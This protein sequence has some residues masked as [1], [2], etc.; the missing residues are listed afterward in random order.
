MLKQKIVLVLLLI[1]VVVADEYYQYSGDEGINIANSDNIIV[2]KSKQYYNVKGSELSLSLQAENT[3]EYSSGIQRNELN[4]AVERMVVSGSYTDDFYENTGKQ[5]E[6]AYEQLYLGGDKYSFNIFNN[7]SSNIKGISLKVFIPPEIRFLLIAPYLSE[8]FNYDTGYNKD[9]GLAEL[10]LN[11]PTLILESNKVT[12]IPL[13]MVWLNFPPIKKEYKI[14]YIIGSE[15]SN[16]Q[17]V[18]KSI[19]F[20]IRTNHKVPIM[21]THNYRGLR[22][23]E[24]NEYDKAVRS[25]ENAVD[26][27]PNNAAFNYNLCAAYLFNRQTKKA[28]PSC[29]KAHKKRGDKDYFVL[30]NLGVIYLKL[31]NYYKSIKYILKALE[32]K[33]DSPIDLRNLQYSLF[34][35]ENKEY[36]INTLSER[37]KELLLIFGSFAGDEKSVLLLIHKNVDVNAKTDVGITALHNVANKGS[38]KIVKELIKYGANIHAVE[39][40][41]NTAIF[42]SERGGHSEV[43][44]FLKKRYQ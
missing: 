11:N 34:H 17:Q 3:T 42:Y 32:L 18:K 29:L 19:I 5:Q 26:N 24:N 43:T 33:T 14:E 31:G 12:K 16:Y 15:T 1:K 40:S 37:E 6:S 20:D 22:Y 8:T 30:G 36:L 9:T 38:I 2:D 27:S 4:Y 13:A 21:Y 10:V 41:G 25:F 28:L 7:N 39:D 35:I 44:T 23:M